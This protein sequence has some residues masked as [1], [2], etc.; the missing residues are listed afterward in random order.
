MATGQPHISAFSKTIRFIVVLWLHWRYQTSWDPDN[1]WDF[2]MLLPIKMAWQVLT[3]YR[4]NIYQHIGKGHLKLSNPHLATSIP[5]SKEHFP[6]L[7]CC[8]ALPMHQIN[9]TMTICA[10]SLAASAGVQPNC[11]NPETRTNTRA[12]MWNLKKEK[13]TFLT[14][15]GGTCILQVPLGP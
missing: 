7:E 13:G 1:S 11:S 3:S 8:W 14:D 6:A 10:G 15:F 5:T 2:W 4:I 12:I 9:E